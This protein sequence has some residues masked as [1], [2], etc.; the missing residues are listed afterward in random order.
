M[1]LL[2][3]IIIGAITVILIVWLIITIIDSVIHCNY[4]YPPEKSELHSTD[5]HGV[6]E[7]MKLNIK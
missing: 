3:D 4:Q 7:K 1:E 5:R 2:F 6:A